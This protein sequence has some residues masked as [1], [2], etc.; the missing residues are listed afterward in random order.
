LVRLVRY[1]GACLEQE[2]RPLAGSDVLAHVLPPQVV[3]L[4]REFPVSISKL[5]TSA[6]SVH[7]ARWPPPHT[8]GAESPSL[9]LVINDTKLLMPCVKCFELGI[10]NACDESVRGKE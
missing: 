9:V 5:Y 10:S 4:E 2:Q 1:L 7:L 8:S 6:S 3:V